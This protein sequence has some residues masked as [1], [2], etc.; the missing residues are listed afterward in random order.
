MGTES[1]FDGARILASILS[2]GGYARAWAREGI[3]AE[4]ANHVRAWP[5]LGWFE[6]G[7]FDPR[8]WA[9]LW[10]NPAFRRATKRDLYWGAKQVLAFS[11]EEIRAAVEVG[12]YREA[13]ADRLHDLLMRRRE[14][15][16]RAFLDLVAPLER[17]R[18]EA[19]GLC[20]EDL[21]VRYDLDRG[22][23]RYRVQGAGPV[24]GGADGARCAEL[25]PGDGY[26]VV[27]LAV[28][29]DGWRRFGPTVRVHYVE[30]HGQRRLVGIE[31]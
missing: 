25:A 28:R 11:S 30:E 4:R 17:F 23:P 1:W 5:E 27:K 15:I 29:R 22:S 19:R 2:L 18:F 12:R 21:M 26:H 20:F 16:G 7:H 3:H 24:R 13:T 10:H 8:T 14:K 31:R 9:P 6:A